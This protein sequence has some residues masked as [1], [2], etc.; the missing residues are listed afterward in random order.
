V[1]RR[2]ITYIIPFGTSPDSYFS[3]I[4]AIL[5]RVDIITKTT[6]DTPT[7]N[8]IKESIYQSP[9]GFVSKY[10]I[11][12]DKVSAQNTVSFICN[13]DNSQDQYLERVDFYHYRSHENVCGNTIVQNDSIK[14]ELINEIS[15]LTNNLHYLNLISLN[16][17]DVP[18]VLRKGLVHT[19]V[20]QI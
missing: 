20:M 10:P 9:E 13:K 15:Y 4:S 12:W 3:T 16:D 18:T 17:L 7:S 19:P 11:N 14:L 6:T 8:E 2:D 1:H 5:S